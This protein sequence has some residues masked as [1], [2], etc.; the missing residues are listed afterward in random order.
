MMTEYKYIADNAWKDARERLTLLEQGADPGTIRNLGLI[1]VQAGWHCLEVAGGGGSIAAWLCNQVGP[2]GY[3]MATDLDPRF[4]EAIIAPNLEVRR[5]NILT[6]PL[7]D[8][9]FDLVHARAL[10]AFLPRPDQ[11]IRTLVAALKPGGWLLLEESDHDSA[12]P[13]PSM[14]PWAT[15]LSQKGWEAL[16][17]FAR[18]RGYDTALGRRLYHDVCTAGLVDVRAEGHVFMQIGGT[19][20]TR[21]WRVTL[22]QQQDHLL[23]AGLLAPAELEEYRTL[24]ESPEYRWLS[25]IGMSVWGRRP[26][27]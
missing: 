22:E 11:V 4:L 23:A 1:G 2:S 8:A 5:H 24:L 18:S 10:L 26:S 7:P 21:F 6:D 13:D 3:V 25:G 17:S 14:A 20:A 15:A 9:V 12:N 27:A 16:L 19:P